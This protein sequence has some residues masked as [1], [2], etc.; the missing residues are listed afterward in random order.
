MLAG[1]AR[2][3]QSGSVGGVHAAAAPDSPDDRRMSGAVAWRR[4]K[5]HAALSSTSYRT[6]LSAV[7]D[8]AKAAVRARSPP[9]REPRVPTLRAFTRSLPRPL[10]P[11]L[12]AA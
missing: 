6:K 8:E 7:I 10:P 9:P 4:A 1:V 3:S 2:P 5:F 11:A 12:D